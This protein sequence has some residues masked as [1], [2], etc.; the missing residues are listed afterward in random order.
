MFSLIKKNLKY[1]KID[2]FYVCIL[3]C[4]MILAIKIQMEKG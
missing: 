1:I 3:L 4:I 2:G